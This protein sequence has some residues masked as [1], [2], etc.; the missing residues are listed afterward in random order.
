MLRTGQSGYYIRLGLY[1]IK[2]SEI[3]DSSMYNCTISL[4]YITRLDL[5]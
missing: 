1:I 4:K 3:A 5:H 2:N